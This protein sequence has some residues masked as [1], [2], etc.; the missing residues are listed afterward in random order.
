MSGRLP[1]PRRVLAL[2]RKELHSTFAQPLLYVVGGVFLLLA[3]YYFYSDLGFFITFA[4]GENIFEN[5]FQLL[6]VDL[7]LVL[8]LTVPLLTMR[9]FAEEKK[10]GTIELLFTYPLSDLEIL[11]AKLIACT[12]AACALLAA[13]SIN[14]AY[15]YQLEPFAF[16]PVLSGYLG[17]GLLAVSFVA[18]GMFLST[19]TDNQVVA[20]MSTVGTLLLLWILSWN[21]STPGAAALG[22]MSR[23]SL[24]N[25]FESFARGVIESK[26]LVYF[27]CLVAF[28]SAATL[29]SLGSR[30]WPRSRLAPT[31][32]GLA[33]LLVA[34]G[35]VDALAER[36]NVRF[37]L[38]PQRRY[39]L[40]PHARRILEKLP[41][42]VEVLA[43][44]RSAD[45]RNASTT[46]LLER[47]GAASPR[48]RHRIVDVNRNPALARRYG[49]NAYGAV[50]VASGER[51]RV[52]SQAR[53]DLLVGAMIDLTRLAPKVVAFTAGHGETEPRD[54]DRARGLSTLTGGLRDDGFE[55]RTLTLDRPVPDDVS[56]V[57]VA[58]GT[59]PWSAAELDRL[60]GWMERGGS[61]LA[62]LDPRQAPELAVWLGER[63]IAPA[64]NVVLDPENRLYGGEGVSIEARPP[65]SWASADRAALPSST[66]VTSTLESGV[67]LSAARALELGAEAQPL[68]ESGAA[69]WATRAIEG[70]EDGSAAFDEERDARGPQVV[71]AARE[72]P[73]IGT[74]ARGARLIVIGDVDVATNRFVEFMSNRQLVQAAIAW[75][76]GEED[77]I[78]LRP[79]RKEG[80][81]EQLFLSAGQAQTSLLIST[82]VVPGTSL[83]IAVALY[84]RRRWG[85]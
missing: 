75:L 33:G 5:F 19:L 71:A 11:L 9:L 4:F 21:E 67:L 38:T 76:V 64:I 53:E 27:A 42:D 69:S 49:V 12:A 65:L 14:L 20:A 70:A 17:L 83:L 39:T 28:A 18:C 2:L 82:V 61:L 47:L 40:S 84:L 10:L 73:P 31:L 72:W 15:L 32:V 13:T 44:V 7:R 48:V 80:G 81:R 57:V 36:Y 45:P 51:H 79:E 3:G 30:A 29:V 6:F 43:F 55:V 58:G 63:G 35:F 8:L 16:G 78:A 60:D 85:A 68:L 25:H 37:D 77:L 22:W 52:L 54:A 26:D 46:D 1:S 41:R 59:Q 24:F 23:L 74:A 50:V 34:L 56:V 62:L 66:L